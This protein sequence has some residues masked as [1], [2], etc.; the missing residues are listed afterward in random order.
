MSVKKTEPDED[1]A[2]NTAE[3]YNP[4]PEKKVTDIIGHHDSGLHKYHGSADPTF[5]IERGIM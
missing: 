1:D 4:D 3:Y 5:L 2:F